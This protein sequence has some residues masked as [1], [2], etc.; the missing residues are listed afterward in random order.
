MKVLAPQTRFEAFWFCSI[1]SS[2]L[3]VLFKPLWSSFFPELIP[4]Y[5]FTNLPPLQ[6]PSLDHWLGTDEVG[7]DLLVRLIFGMGYS[8][9][10]GAAVAGGTL[11][12][13]TGIGLL[14]CFLPFNLGYF[15]VVFQECLAALPF[16]PLALVLLIFFPGNILWIAGLKI[17]LSWPTVS[18][19]VFQEARLMRHSP[20]IQSATSQGLSRTRIA[21]LFFTPQF[22]PLLRGLFETAFISAILSLATLDFFG[23]GFPIPTPTLP[24]GF[25]Q[26]LEHSEAWWL[27]VFPLFFLIFVLGGLRLFRPVDQEP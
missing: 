1:L 26:F 21:L 12:L 24:E 6:G 3:L 11:I 4:E 22:I 15:S 7:R 2:I 19:I 25:R 20:L 17:L 16:L 5:V 13:G 10:F 14:F 23:L 9:F 8:C 27:F 18:H